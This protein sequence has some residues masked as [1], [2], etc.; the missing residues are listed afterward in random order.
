MTLKQELLNRRANLEAQ[1][2][3]YVANA[4]AAQGAL[5]SLDS[6]LQLLEK[7]NPIG[8]SLLVDD[9]LPPPATTSE[10]ASA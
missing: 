4:N 6:I 1:K 3:Q 8:A 2:E 7:N 5:N 10:A 9:K